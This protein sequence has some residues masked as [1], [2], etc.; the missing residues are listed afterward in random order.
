[1]AG[2]NMIDEPKVATLDQLSI[3]ADECGQSNK[4]KYFSDGTGEVRL[5]DGGIWNPQ[6]ILKQNYQLLELLIDKFDC[7]LFRDQEIYEFFIYQYTDGDN[8]GPPKAHGPT[9]PGVTWNAAMTLWFGE[10]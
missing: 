9:L 10:E 6:F 3:L 5:D 8:D 2:I 1:M 7:R 4:I